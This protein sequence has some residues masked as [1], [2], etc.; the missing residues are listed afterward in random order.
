[1]KKKGKRLEAENLEMVKS[2]AKHL[3]K[4]G[5]GKEETGSLMGLGEERLW[6]EVDRL[7]WLVRCMA[8][9]GGL[10]HGQM[11]WCGAVVYPYP[12]RAKDLEATPKAEEVRGCEE[13]HE[14]QCQEDWKG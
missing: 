10:A 2:K 14:R 4:E 7:W 12:R 5:K 8:W 3:K 1:M 6:S 11:C 13:R 9:G